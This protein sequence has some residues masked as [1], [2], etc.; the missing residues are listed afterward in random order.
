MIFYFSGTGNSRWVA[1][2][3]ACLLGDQ[4]CD[5]TALT[6]IPDIKK[7]K[8][9]GFVF[10]IYAW[11]A[12]EPMEAFAMK[13]PKTGAFSFGVCTCGEEA[14]MAM[15]QFSKCYPLDS[16]YSLVM[17]NNYIVG[18]DTE[19]RF[20][21]KSTLPEKNCRR[22]PVRSYSAKRFIMWRKVLLLA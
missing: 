18:T 5:I 13:L 16:S 10:P 3:L 8:Q 4:T 12:P 21:Q 14:G 11:G 15:K 6:E 2:Q 20:M 17:P 7:E 22:F 9:I 1:K 19:R